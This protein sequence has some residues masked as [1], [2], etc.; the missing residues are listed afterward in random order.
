[1]ATKKGKT[2]KQKNN[3]SVLARFFKNAAGKLFRRKAHV[4][5]LLLQKSYRQKKMG[6][7]KQAVT[8]GDAKNVLRLCPSL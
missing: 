3:K 7:T 2:G 8:R 5:H 6:L 4:R 1:M